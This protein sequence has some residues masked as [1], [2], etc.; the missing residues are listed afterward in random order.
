MMVGVCAGGA[1]KVRCCYTLRYG[2]R[3][4]IQS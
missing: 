3:K 4:A 2:V 1:F